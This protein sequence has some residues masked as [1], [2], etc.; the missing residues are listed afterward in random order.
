MSL[1]QRL[2][3]RLGGASEPAERAPPSVEAAPAPAPRVEAELP[4]LA[5]L[6]RGDQVEERVALG[7]LER[8]RGTSGERAAL[9]FVEAAAQ[10]G[11]ATESLRTRAA[12]LLLS[13]G[14]PGRALALL[15][16]ASSAAALLLAADA[17]AETGE[18]ARALTLVERVLA[19]DIDAPG[20]RE[21]HERWRRA[22]GGRTPALRSALAEP[23]LL[24]AEAP[25]TSLRI[26]AEAGRGGAG[27]VFEAIDDAL[28]R[29]VALKIY[30]QPERERDKLA[31]EARTAVRLAGA[32]VVRV[33]DVDLARGFL[34]MEWLAEGSL[35]QRIA[36]GDAAYLSPIERWLTPLV[37][38]LGRVHAAGLVH[39]DLKPANVMFRQPDEPVLSDFGLAH[40]A[41]EIVVGGSVG[42]MSPER[43]RGG[44]VGFAEDLYGIGR[45]LEDVLSVVEADVRWRRL[46]DRLLTG[47][48]ELGDARALLALL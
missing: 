11:L 6:A 43:V 48:P 32:G 25:E 39:A 7:E 46:A 5:A 23:T 16:G 8:A 10:A 2:K 41:E 44:S 42:Y 22:L 15:G 21:R 3:R 12:E 18:V 28:G 14:E 1:W 35:K 29:R 17:S 27:T 26:V 30:H 19:R 37:R 33:F 40:R 4:P 36:A 31:R 9:G 47:A 20:A 38:A 13:R 45:L 34:V 24:R